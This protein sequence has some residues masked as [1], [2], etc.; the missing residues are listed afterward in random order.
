[1]KSLVFLTFGLAS[2]TPLLAAP[3]TAQAAARKTPTGKFSAML[4]EAAGRDGKPSLSMR[5]LEELVGEKD[6]TKE[7]KILIQSPKWIYQFS[8][9]RR[10]EVVKGGEGVALAAVVDGKKVE[11]VWK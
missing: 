10:L 2:L 1:M 9:G 6:E 4:A 5:E 3:N 7:T 11:L 8:G